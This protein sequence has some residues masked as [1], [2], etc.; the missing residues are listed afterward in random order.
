MWIKSDSQLID[1]LI[2]YAYNLASQIT[3]I[4]YP[5]THVVVHTHLQ[6]TGPSA[7]DVSAIG[8]L[9]Q[10]SSWIYEFF[11]GGLTKFFTK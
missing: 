3:S 7:A 2:S 9:G 8:R 5:S 1:N 10:K 4:T 11:G 6:T